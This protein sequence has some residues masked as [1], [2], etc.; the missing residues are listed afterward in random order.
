MLK[1]KSPLGLK[2]PT[3]LFLNWSVKVHTPSE[4]KAGNDSI[5]CALYH[6]PQ[7]CLLSVLNYV[8]WHYVK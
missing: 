4:Y 3:V 5:S 6:V 2:E 1:F 7:L 8:A